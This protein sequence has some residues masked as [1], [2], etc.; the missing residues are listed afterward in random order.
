MAGVV[1]MVLW[2]C[3]APACF[4]LLCFAVLLA[5]EKGLMKMRGD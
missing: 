2:L 5:F 1:F 4:A 3:D